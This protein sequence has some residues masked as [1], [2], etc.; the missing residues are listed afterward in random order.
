MPY[1]RTDHCVSVQFHTWE[2]PI[3]HRL[4]E[5]TACHSL[6]DLLRTA[7]NALLLESDDDAE[8]VERRPPPGRVATGGQGKPS[9]GARRVLARLQQGATTKAELAAITGGIDAR[10]S[11]LRKAGYVIS[12]PAAG[13]YRLEGKAEA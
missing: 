6:S 2:L 1:R 11:E 13:V 3:L 5:Q 10:V 8:L 4:K 12:R 7:V 9:R